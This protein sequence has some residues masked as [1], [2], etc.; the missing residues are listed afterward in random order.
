MEKSLK[1]LQKKDIILNMCITVSKHF[2]NIFSFLEIII[3]KKKKAI[4]H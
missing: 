2:A 4:I 3:L 1:N